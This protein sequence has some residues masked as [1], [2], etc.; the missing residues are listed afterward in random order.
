M[1]LLARSFAI[2]VL[3]VG[4]CSN[5][6]FADM[7]G[8]MA[9]GGPNSPDA[10]S[11]RASRGIVYT[12]VPLDEDV[13]RQLAE[14]KALVAAGKLSEAIPVFEK[15]VEAD[16]PAALPEYARAL[17]LN[18]EAEK[19]T[20]LLARLDADKFDLLTRAR[21]MMAAGRREEGV[22]LLK[23]APEVADGSDV[24]ATKLL[25]RHL[26]QD[27]GDHLLA[28]TLGR[29]KDAAGR[30]VLFKTLFDNEK[31][32]LEDHPDLIVSAV[33]AGLSALGP[34]RAEA[35]R[36]M[37]STIIVWQQ[38]AH[39]FPLRDAIKKEAAASGRAGSAWLVARMLV[40]EER[41][42]DALESLTQ[43]EA[44]FREDKLW[45]LL[46]EERA[47]VLRSLGKLPESRAALESV[48]AATTDPNLLRE[49]ARA[50][51]AVNE[52]ATA[53]ETLARIDEE[54]APPDEIRQNNMLRMMAVVRT[55]NV[56]EILNTYAKAMAQPMADDY[57]ML[58]GIIFRAVRD[59]VEIRKIED[60]IRERFQED[61]D[62]TPSVLWML[63]AEAA[64]QGN[65]PPN[66]VEALYNAAKA[67]P[68]DVVVMQKLVD[69]V[70]PLVKQ[71]VDTP[72]DQVAAPKGEVERLNRIAD[73]ALMELSLA[74]PLDPTPYVAMIDLFKARKTDNIPERILAINAR[75]SVDSRVIGVAAY[76]LATTGYAAEAL[77]VYDRA[78]E[79]D[80]WNYDVKMNRASCLTRLGRWKDAAAVYE[81]TVMNGYRGRNYHI[82]EMLGRLYDCYEQMNDLP[83]FIKWVDEASDK[84]NPDWRDELTIDSANLLSNKGRLNDALPFYRK[85][86]TGAKE[87]KN[88]KK[89]YDNLGGALFHAERYEEA[90]A[91]YTEAI[92]K[93]PDGEEAL[94][95]SLSCG[96]CQVR[97][98]DP[99]KAI[100]QFESVAARWPTSQRAV[101]SLYRASLV[102]N[103]AQLA[104]KEAA[105]L[106]AFLDSS[107]TD[108]AA[109]KQATARLAELQS[110]AKDT[111]K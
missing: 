38:G 99:V 5:S 39:Y 21:T 7:P 56:P 76:A 68:G 37:D 67:R 41:Y 95:F 29:C 91:V 70:L 65:R 100:A 46:A 27:E 83:A 63:A 50:Q 52:N 58:H 13:R 18:G 14:A 23:G 84:V 94:E 53:L 105:L 106:K 104:E 8:A 85:M 98:K 66:Q 110:P 20:A 2:T 22:A 34:N 17:K 6:L 72:S 73:E 12:G 24:A 28:E 57:D 111:S 79:F 107:S 55:G 78:L 87:P 10:K 4:S 109:R 11:V 26:P 40:R 71:L 3:L 69:C 96:E 9:L 86:T 36:I 102:A 74:Q 15:A 90:L 33:D 108:F 16:A 31:L 47:E 59:T 35:V 62:K 89:A 82:H 49:T 77:P 101:G 43:S 93:F 60:S 88:V 25:A 103:E 51:M 48:A 42:S 75:R 80:P 61:G 44:Q 30:V 54:G 64:L 81:D 92:S 1:R 97:L 19:V 45:P 32:V